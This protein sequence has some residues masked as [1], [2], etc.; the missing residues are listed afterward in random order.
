MSDVKSLE[1]PTL[2]VSIRLL[3]RR[4]VNNSSLCPELGNVARFSRINRTLCGPVAAVN[5]A[6]CDL[7]VNSLK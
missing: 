2:K 3:L 7:K 6:V 5:T 4:L 1:H